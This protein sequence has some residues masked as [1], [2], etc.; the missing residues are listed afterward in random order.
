MKKIISIT[1][2]MFLLNINFA[3][4]E[5]WVTITA[6]NGKS[7]DLDLDS[8]Q[9]A[10]DTVEYDIRTQNNDFI[11]INK[12]STELYKEGIPTAVIERSKY[13]NDLSEN[14]KISDEKI[15]IRDYR[16]LKSGTLQA[17]IFDVL[18]KELDK[19]SFTHGKSTWNKYLKRQ[20]KEIYK[21]WK[22]YGNYWNTY[23]NSTSPVYFDD[24]LLIVDK[25]GIIQ[26]KEHDRR[27]LPELS[28]IEPLPEDY[29]AETFQLDVKMNYYKYAGA[30]LN[31]K[32]PVVKQISPVRSEIT[33]SKNKRPPVL[34]HIQLGFLWCYK[35]LDNFKLPEPPDNGVLCLIGLPFAIAGFICGL[36]GQIV[37]GIF[38]FISGVDM[39]DL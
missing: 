33:I 8:I 14:N 12:M 32:K 3:Y 36:A 31:T 13:K 28:V 27:S 19:K 11:Y 21:H 7:A 16:I 38:C 29:T 10:V 15:D 4:A 23:S 26:R 25:N 18:S 22:P 39:N 5:N 2:I 34:G 20:R 35:K 9:M 37:C 30:K 24:V 17:E 6:E 1:L